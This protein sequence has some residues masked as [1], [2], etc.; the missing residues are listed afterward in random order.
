MT[1]FNYDVL[2]MSR[3]KKN[4]KQTGSIKCCDWHATYINETVRNLSSRLTEYKRE[5]RNGDV[6]NHLQ[7][8]HQID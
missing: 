1:T 7:T 3:T 4:R 2:L 6:N 8:K 5:T